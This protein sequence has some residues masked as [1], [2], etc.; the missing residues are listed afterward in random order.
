MEHTSLRT[1]RAFAAL[2]AFPALRASVA[3]G[4][5]RQAARVA[6]V[7]ARF[8]ERPDLFA[9][10]ERAL[11]YSPGGMVALVGEPGSGVT[12]TLAALAARLPAPLWLSADDAGMGARAL[13][14]QILALYRP[15]VP[16]VD[17][18][19]ATDPLTI[20]RLLTDAAAARS[21][22]HPIVLLVDAPEPAQRP[23]SLP[24]PADLPVGV[25]LVYGCSPGDALPYPARTTLALTD[26]TPD[27]D[28]QRRA[29]QALGCPPT[30][31]EALIAAAQGN[32]LY[33]ELAVNALLNGLLDPAHLPLGLEA[34]FNGWWNQH[35][36]GERR[37]AELIA[38]AGEPLPLP[39]I[40]ELLAADPMPTLAQWESLGLIDLTLQT[41]PGAERAEPTILAAFSHSAPR[42]WIG[43]AQET[44]I[45]QAH[46]ELA[47]LGFARRNR[48]TAEQPATAAYLHRQA[49]RHAAL[50][51]QSIRTAQLRH[52]TSRA[53]VSD[54]ERRT[55]L[56]AAYNDVA[57]EL[58]A[59]ADA[60]TDAGRTVLAA[61]LAGTLATR[62]RML[63]PDAAVEALVIG[64]ERS[65]R[66][67]ALKRV[68]DVVERLPDG[69][70]KALILR[71][72]GEACY[73]ARMRQSA[74]R[75][76]SRALDLEANPTSRA[77]RDQREQLLAALAG[78]AIA[79]GAIDAALAIA[80]RIEHLERRAV[81]ETQAAR[82]LLEDGDRDR[83]QRLA[84]SILHESMGAWARAEVAV[85][86][87][88]AGD[89]R[90]ALM[91]DEIGNETATIWAQIELACDVAATDPVAARAR[92]DGL[93]NPGQHDRGLARLALALAQAGAE[94]AA[95]H[96]ALDIQAA[97]VRLTAL[98]ELRHMLA[99]DASLAALNQ[100]AAYLDALHA[101]DRTPL[102][103]ALAAA[104]AA[105]GQTGQA[106]SLV[107]ELPEGEERDRARARTAVAL[108]RRGDYTAALR[109]LDALDDEDERDWAR[110]EIVRLLA[111]DGLWD[112]ALTLINAIAAPE[113]RARTNADLAIE[114]GRAG[115]PQ[116]ALAL[117]LA[118]EDPTERARALALLAPILVTRGAPALAHAVIAHPEALTGSE[119]RNRYLAALAA[120]LATSGDLAA[121]QSVSA[122][123][124]RPVERA[125]AELACAAAMAPNDPQ[126]AQRALSTA[127][128]A[129]AIGREEVLRTIE[130]AAP[131]LAVLGGPALIT[132]IAEDIL[133]IDGS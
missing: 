41:T 70:D 86:L 98:V 23:L 101:D 37:L 10:L 22:A 29:L 113:Q 48:R 92:I 117:A 67:A 72:L 24:L 65:G 126:A 96:T 18:A 34:L 93:S 25:T 123:I 91:L 9:A 69:S 42:R 95:L 114:R 104:F 43:A 112:E 60:N 76:L 63:S 5:E 64:L 77:W 36:A 26:F 89:Q 120:A 14:A 102:L 132:R 97:D 44:G 53:W 127:L 12:S 79:Q 2:D 54:H 87:L 30:H 20:E 21:S 7:L 71:R 51:P 130:W 125:R 110:D 128:C 17:P 78:T 73:E 85:A 81:V 1:P 52:V 3:A 19:T 90:G 133:A 61:A 75:L 31:M 103:A 88:R 62:A 83:A 32:L 6:A 66:E 39:L 47:E 50:G 45:A 49:A 109:I 46:G 15:G 99:G 35:T 119:A 131:T 8:Q 40:N 11:A 58:Q 111:A 28:M 129:T 106:L 124:R 100:A 27:A 13:Y 84:R 16:L 74:M 68:L 55:T 4:T 118:V 121:A 82:R 108:T 59:A 107:L 105:L 122:Q 94:T 33:L 57:W 80:E 56:E 116:A 38:A 115:E